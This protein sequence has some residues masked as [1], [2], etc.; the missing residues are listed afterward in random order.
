M[1][2]RGRIL[3]VDDEANARSALA[4]LFA[5]EGY[6]VETA[7]DGLAAMPKLDSFQPD[8]VLT[9]LRMPGMSGIELMRQSRT[10]DPE[11]VFVVMTAQGTADS[12]VTALLEG[13]CAY[14]RKPLRFDDI[15]RAVDEVLV[16]RRRRRR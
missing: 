15:A 2:P 7:P 8:L 1:T 5:G 13:A 4:E 6:S 3:I 12:A 14:L 16:Q 11:R 10:Q 9:D